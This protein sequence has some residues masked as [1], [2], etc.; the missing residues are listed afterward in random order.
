MFGFLK[1]N[2]ECSIYSPVN[3]IC[4]PIEECGDQMFA[5]KILGDGVAFELKDDV[6]YAPCDGEVS[7]IADTKHAFGINSSN[8][9]EILVHVGF[10][11]TGLM[12][13]GFETYVSQGDTVKKG[14]KILK[15]DINYI[16]SQN[17]KCVTPMI[18][19]S[20]DNYDLEIHNVYGEVST[21]TLTITTK[22]K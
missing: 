14:Q 22:K 6:I 19:T 1:K 8:G 15:V 2:A 21:D 7:V 18:I 16:K 4:F 5:Q 11:T 3:G 10:E 13:K 20:S 12:G 17:L 9:T